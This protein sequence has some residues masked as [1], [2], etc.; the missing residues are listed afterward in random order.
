MSYLIE[1][2]SN[3][4]LNYSKDEK[5][6]LLSEKTTCINCG[7]VIFPDDSFCATCGEIISSKSSEVQITTTEPIIHTKSYIQT[8]YAHELLALI[9]SEDKIQ[10]FYE[11]S[12]WP[13]SLR[14]SFAALTDK[15]LYF[16]DKFI[17]RKTGSM[18]LRDIKKLKFEERNW[19]LVVVGI[20]LIFPFFP[21]GITAILGAVLI[22][23]GL[24]YGLTIETY[25]FHKYTIRG[26]ENRIRALH[27]EIYRKVK[28]KES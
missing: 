24:E 20:I 16:Y 7:S 10:E 4:E 12:D 3:K 18:S 11:V 1:F 6:L 22:A 9:R 27:A 15:R 28:A 25:H 21:L 14:K 5:G 17:E 8:V 19:F 23:K 26:N 13:F 2:I